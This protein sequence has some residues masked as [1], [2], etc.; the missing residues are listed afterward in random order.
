MAST[1][2]LGGS[3]GGRMWD[4]W[5]FFTCLLGKR[6]GCGAAGLVGFHQEDIIRIGFIVTVQKMTRFPH[7]RGSGPETTELHDQI[8][9]S[10]FSKLISTGH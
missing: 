1:Q 7:I 5:N 6:R 9:L 10:L 3:R 2:S 8:L 4:L